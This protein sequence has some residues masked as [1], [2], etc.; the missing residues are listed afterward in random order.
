MERDVGRGE[1]RL[2][3]P[4]RGGA[5]FALVIVFRIDAPKHLAG[6]IHE[7]P[8]RGGSCRRLGLSRSFRRLMV[9]RPRVTF[10][11][12]ID[13]AEEM[14]R[15][16]GVIFRSDPISGDLGVTRQPQIPFKQLVGIATSPH[17]NPF[18]AERLVS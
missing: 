18:A 7:R 2:N 11:T 3:K 10:S 15:M 8:S 12:G 6:A 13:R 1:V 14:L 16:L 17:L 4:T 5:G 9:S